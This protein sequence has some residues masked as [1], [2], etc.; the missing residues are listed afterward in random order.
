MGDQGRGLGEHLVTLG[1]FGG[2]KRDLGDAMGLSCQ[3]LLYSCKTAF[4]S[5]ID[6]I[7]SLSSFLLKLS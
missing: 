3:S 1:N 6:E 2:T 4:G 7:L 5:S